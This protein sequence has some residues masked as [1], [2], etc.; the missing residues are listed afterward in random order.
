MC[1]DRHATMIVIIGNM[2]SPLLAVHP[3]RC[4]LVRNRNAD[5]LRCAQACLSGA[6]SLG[7]EGVVVDPALCIGC[8]T[9]ASV[10]P[11]CCLEAKNPSDEDLIAQAVQAAAD[12]GDGTVAVVCSEARS[13]ALRLVGET[14]EPCEG[15]RLASNGIPA[16]G[17][18]CLG[19]IEESFL[20]EMAARGMRKISLVHGNCGHCRHQSGSSLNE[21]FCREASALLEALGSDLAI[22]RLSVEEAGLE[23]I[24]KDASRPGTSKRAVFA[25]DREEIQEETARADAYDSRSSVKFMHVQADGTLPHHLPQRRLRLFNSMKRLNA[26]PVGTIETRLWGSVSLNTELCRSCRMCTVFCPTAAISRYEGE[27]GSFGV[28]HAPALCVQCRMC[29]TICPEGAISVSGEVRL[30]DVL[31]GKRVRFSMKEL[32]WH[33]GQDDAI[34]TRMARFIKVDALQDPQAKA[35]PQEVSRMRAYATDRQTRREEI[36]SAATCDS[37]DGKRA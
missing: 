3:N 37:E 11:T 1:Y 4:M 36:R 17:V 8:G 27:N 21:K 23:P 30:G 26:K 33:P 19:R 32:G 35:K 22:E 18:M 9:C 28:E 16:V 25:H 2:D 34:V 5:C 31:S 10:C 29:E 20:V 7:E 12:E 6:I 24:T 13:T 14:S 15:V